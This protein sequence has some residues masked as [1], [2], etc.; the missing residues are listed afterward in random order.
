[1]LYEEWY[2]YMSAIARI[3]RAVSAWVADYMP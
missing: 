2:N 3:V 1:M